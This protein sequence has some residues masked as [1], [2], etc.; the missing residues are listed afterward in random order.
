MVPPR[1]AAS[2]SWRD[3]A[4]SFSA[5]P[6]SLRT[7]STSSPSAAASRITRDSSWASS[8]TLRP[9]S[10]RRAR[11]RRSRAS[12]LRVKLAT[13]PSRRLARAARSHIWA[14]VFITS[15]GVLPEG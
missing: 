4:A 15:G 5:T 13:S 14:R 2:A 1:T 9:I 12:S 7:F 3:W 6:S 10:A 8:S 11:P